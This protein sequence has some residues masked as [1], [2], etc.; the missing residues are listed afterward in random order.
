MIGL[1]L[2]SHQSKYLKDSVAGR[3]ASRRLFDK[4]KA[5]SPGGITKVELLDGLLH[6]EPS[7]KISADELD[8]AFPFFNSNNDGTV[9]FEEFASV[10]A[11][12][13]PSVT[14]TQWSDQIAGVSA[15]SIPTLSPISKTRSLTL[16]RPT[17][18]P[19]SKTRSLTWPRPNASPNSNPRSLALYKPVSSP[20]LTVRSLFSD[21]AA[22]LNS[23]QKFKHKKG[24][25]LSRRMKRRMQKRKD[26]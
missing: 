6:I 7:L 4:F 8:L 5:H 2:P 17:L 14:I 19:I 20:A 16:Y 23:P 11:P 3:Q 24:V 13:S 18:S 1:V 15:K 9:S 26:N 12:G 25:A 21:R 10:I 22:Q